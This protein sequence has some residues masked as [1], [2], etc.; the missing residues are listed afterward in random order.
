[1]KNLFVFLPLFFSGKMVFDNSFCRVLWAFFAYIFRE[2][3]KAKWISFAVIALV[4]VGI[5]GGLSAIYTPT[6]ALEGAMSQFFQVGVVLVPIVLI[7]FYNG[8]KGSKHPIHKWFFYVF[9]P[10]HLLALYLIKL[11]IGM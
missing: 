4:E 8:E 11:A 2:N 7:F 5:I 1:M 3:P 9:Y 6:T 10:A